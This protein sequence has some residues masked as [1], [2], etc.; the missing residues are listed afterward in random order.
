LHF[1]RAVKQAI[2]LGVGLAAR[3]HAAHAEHHSATNPRGCHAAL[4]L[5]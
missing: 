2:V 4:V 5:I 1:V 3:V